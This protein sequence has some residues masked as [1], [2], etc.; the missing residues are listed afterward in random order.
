MSATNS[1]ANRMERYHYS[2]DDRALGYKFKKE[3]EKKFDDFIAD[4]KVQSLVLGEYNVQKEPW[5]N[6]AIVE[7]ARE[8]DLKVIAKEKEDPLL[9]FTIVKKKLSMQRL[10]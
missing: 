3:L 7:L 6:M 9:E 1:W 5:R 2:Q 4:A 10:H 8:R